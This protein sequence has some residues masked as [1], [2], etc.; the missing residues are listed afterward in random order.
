M[1]SPVPKLDSRERFAGL[2]LG[3]AGGIRWGCP[4]RDC[5]AA[6]SSGFPPDKSGVW[7]AGSGPAM[8][9]AI[10]QNVY[11]RTNVGL[12]VNRTELEQFK[13]IYL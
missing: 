5:R 9:R 7:S 1:Q 12:W 13:R 4:P 2:L 11:C 3:T 8:R 6:G 10:I